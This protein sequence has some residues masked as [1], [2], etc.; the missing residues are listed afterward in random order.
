MYSRQYCLS[1][2]PRLLGGVKLA[3]GLKKSVDWH[4]H[5]VHCVSRWHLTPY[6]DIMERCE[7]NKRPR[8]SERSAEFS[9]VSCAHGNSFLELNTTRP[10][11]SSA[12]QQSY[13]K[14]LL[15]LWFLCLLCG[16]KG[17]SSGCPKQLVSSRPEAVF[18]RSLR[19]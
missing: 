2:F 6:A 8:A 17:T 13:R 18:G 16:F 1:T 7:V 10:S 15:C 12:P 3:M 5:L 4:I 9:W 19:L 14:R 11:L